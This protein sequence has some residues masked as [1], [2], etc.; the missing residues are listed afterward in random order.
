M[1]DGNPFKV[2]EHHGYRTDRGWTRPLRDFTDDTVDVWSQKQ[3]EDFNVKLLGEH[4]TFENEE[5]ASYVVRYFVQG[6]MKVHTEFPDQILD[7]D[8]IFLQAT[9]SANDFI[10]R[11]DHG[12]LKYLRAKPEGAETFDENAPAVVDNRGNRKRKKGAKKEMAAEMYQARRLELTRGEMIAVF[13]EEIGM[14]KPGATTYFH[15]NKAAHGPCK[16]A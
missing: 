2:L 4:V 16:E 11:M 12:D 13:M 15:N 7:V 9:E 8:A 6:L 3:F 14:S 5:Q 1:A 10:R